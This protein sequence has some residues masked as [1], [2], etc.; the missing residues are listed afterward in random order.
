MI[1]GRR[2]VLS[3]SDQTNA[4]MPDDG[5]VR[6]AKSLEH[7]WLRALLTRAPSSSNKART[8]TGRVSGDAHVHKLHRRGAHALGNAEKEHRMGTQE[9]SIAWGRR[10]GAS[11]GDA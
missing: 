10:K 6:R 5:R 1:T 8:R 11:H 9:G 7:G 2:P 3:L 4:S